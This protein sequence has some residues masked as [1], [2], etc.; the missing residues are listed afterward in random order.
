MRQADTWYETFREYKN[1]GNITFFS[2]QSPYI[3][4]SINDFH[5]YSH[6]MGPKETMRAHQ[7]SGDVLVKM[8][9]SDISVQGDTGE[10]YYDPDKRRIKG[11]VIDSSNNVVD[12]GFPVLLQKLSGEGVSL[13]TGEWIE[14]N[15]HSP[16]LIYPLDVNKSLKDWGQWT[17]FLQKDTCPMCLYPRKDFLIAELSVS[18]LYLSPNQRWLGYV[19]AVFNDHKTDLH[20]LNLADNVR[21]YEDAMTALK[22]VNKAFHPEKMN[23]DNLGNKIPHLHW[24]II[25]RYAGDENWRNPTWA[26]WYEG[27]HSHLSREQYKTIMSAI[28]A[29]L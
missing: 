16:I 27:K 24:H 10:R 25:P 5:L 8:M 3:D 1:K 11:Q 17:T 9:V 21:F 28:K 14:A 29:F 26:D 15:W 6:W 19:Y 23:I 22:A 12:I 2:S 7:W 13:K 4:V 18:K 20:Q